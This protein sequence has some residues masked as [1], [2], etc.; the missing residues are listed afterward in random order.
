M[1]VYTAGSW[2]EAGVFMRG[3]LGQGARIDGPAIIVEPN[4]T[5]V[6]EPGWRAEITP[7]DHVVLTRVV[8]AERR[9]AVGTK[10]DPVM[11]EVFNN[12]SCRSPSRWAWRCRT[13]PTP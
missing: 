9:A 8:A 5:I 3:D 13:P 1:R 10:A 11:L 2:R 12:C 7:K 6:V 4:Q